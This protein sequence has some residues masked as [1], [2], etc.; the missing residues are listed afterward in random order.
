MHA[1]LAGLAGR[2]WLAD[3]EPV[4]LTDTGRRRTRRSPARFR[5]DRES[6]VEGLTAEQYAETARVLAVM[7]ANVERTL[8]G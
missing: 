6:V 4:A 3:G 2:G 5:R 1:V 7:A 8:A